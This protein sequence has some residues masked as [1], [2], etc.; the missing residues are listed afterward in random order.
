VGLCSSDWEVFQAGSEWD[1]T[2]VKHL[3]QKSPSTDVPNPTEYQGYAG[4]PR[5]VGLHSM[6][7]ALAKG[8][9]VEEVTSR[10]KR[11][12]WSLKRLHDIFIS[13]ITA[14]PIYELK[15]A[16]SLHAHYCAEH[17]SELA[18]RVP[19]MRPAPHG[20][21]VSPDSSLDLFFNEVKAAPGVEELV[22]GLYEFAVPAVVRA[23]ESLI[24]NTNKLFDHPNVP[25][26]PL[27]SAGNA[28]RVRI[29]GPCRRMSD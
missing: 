26:M 4:L 17:M 8:L 11:L 19:E 12:H 9:P 1:P 25:H 22:L 3:I 27:R 21:E 16:F 5:L 15:M 13:R 18:A 6:S 14:M 7:E 29:R 28:R 20:L 24:A 2:R 10:I 23:L